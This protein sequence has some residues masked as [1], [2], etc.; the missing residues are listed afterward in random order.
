MTTRAL[1]VEERRTAPR[2]STSF[3]AEL[4]SGTVLVPVTVQDLSVTGCGVVIAGG[5]PDLPDKVG[6]RGLVHLPA[7]DRGT[8]GTVLPVALRNVRHAGRLVIYGLEF[9][10]LLAHQTRKLMGVLEAM[11]TDG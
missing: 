10:P 3:A 8:Y 6:G 2:F 5:D 7:V 9:G 1:M 11:C 4:A